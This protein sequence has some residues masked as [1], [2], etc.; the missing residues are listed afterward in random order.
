MI[1]NRKFIFGVIV[2]FSLVTFNVVR[3]Q[4]DTKQKT[5]TQQANQLQEGYAIL[6]KLAQAE[7]R[8]LAMHPHHQFTDSDA[9]RIMQLLLDYPKLREEF[10]KLGYVS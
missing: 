5:T 7:P 10:E 8:W 6:E 3:G 4:V 9:E 1:I 2:M